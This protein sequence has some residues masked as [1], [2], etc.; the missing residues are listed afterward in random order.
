MRIYEMCLDCG[1][2]TFFVSKE[3]GECGTNEECSVCGG[4]HIGFEGDKND[5]C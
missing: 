4:S 5:K 1:N 2:N 3:K